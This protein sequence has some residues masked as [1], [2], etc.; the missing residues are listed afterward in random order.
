M[1]QSMRADLFQRVVQLVL[2]FGSSEVWNTLPVNGSNAARTAAASPSPTESTSAD[3]PGVKALPTSVTNFLSSPRSSSLPISAPPA[4]PM[5]RPARG[6]MK[7]SAAP[8]TPPR[9][10]PH[11]TSR[12]T[13]LCT[14]SSPALSRSTVAASCSVSWPS[15]WIC[16]IA[17]RA[18]SA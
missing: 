16:L 15:R 14:R 17:A 8:K 13:S 3:E 11:L 9:P 5:A 7:V 18:C 4:A 6:N 2:E 1:V 12:L 10:A